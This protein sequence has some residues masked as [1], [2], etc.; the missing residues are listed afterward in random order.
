[1]SI[2]IEQKEI[3]GKQKEG[4]KHECIKYIKHLRYDDRVWFI[5][6]AG[7][8]YRVIV[9][10]SHDYKFVLPQPAGFFRKTKTCFPWLFWRAI[11][12]SFRVKRTMNLQFFLILFW[13]NLFSKEVWMNVKYR[14]IRPIPVRNVFWYTLCHSPKKLVPRSDIA[15]FIMQ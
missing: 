9:W 10:F 3:D 1:M 8:L 4:W 6:G 14:L 2:K 7:R 11:P 12:M 13:Q 15:P 5:Y